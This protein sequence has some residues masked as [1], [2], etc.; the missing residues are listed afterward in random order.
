[1]EKI[2]ILVTSAGSINGINVISSLGKSKKFDITIHVADCSE[3]SAAFYLGYKK[4]LLPKASAKTFISALV[5]YIQKENIRAIIPTHSA[6]LSAFIENKLLI[7]S[8]GAKLLLHERSTI[9]ISEDK[10]KMI[11]A[12]SLFNIPIPKEYSFEEILCGNFFPIFKKN[13]FGSGAKNAR[14]LCGHEDLI[15]FMGREIEEPIYQE[16][17][18]GDEYTISIFQEGKDFFMLPIKRTKVSGGMSVICESVCF[19][20]PIRKE[21]ELICRKIS[22]LFKFN[23]PAN[24]QIKIAADGKIF[25]L[26]FN[27]RFPCGTY[28]CAY[29][30]GFDMSDMILSKLFGIPIELSLNYGIK[31]IRHWSYVAYVVRG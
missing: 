7:E 31:I 6:E 5:D 27:P 12:F 24:I 19:D 4:V 8:Y 10:R 18:E 11:D 23:G 20:D 26:E 29:E 9:D 14:K 3:D 30:S 16:Y 22:K 2:N 25:V 13:R 28:P 1:M 21:V 15:Y 17:I